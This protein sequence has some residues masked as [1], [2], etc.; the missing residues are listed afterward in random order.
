[1]ET[2]LDGETL[3][4]GRIF[5][6]RRTRVRLDDGR[7]A[8]RDWV[9]HPGSVVVAAMTAAREVILVRQYRL[10]A[11]RE[12]WELPA[13][14]REPGE[15]P[16][17]GAQRELEEETGLKARTWRLLARFYASP[18][19]TSEHKWLYLAQDLER[20]PSHPDPDEQL[21]VRAVPL[22]EALRMAERGEIADAKTLVG[23]LI[24]ERGGLLVEP[25]AGADE[26]RRAASPGDP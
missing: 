10:P 11:G 25:A 5:S 19:Y 1:M 7:E 17:H 24:L 16:L 20:G 26:P 9:D 21:A 4:N 14:R 3:W 12:L 13:G 22:D 6:L 18:G 8:V 15:D 23:L 2:P